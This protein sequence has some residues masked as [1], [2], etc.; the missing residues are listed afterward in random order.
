MQMPLGTIRAV[1]SA[2]ASGAALRINTS[3]QELEERVLLARRFI[4]DIL[5]TLAAETLDDAVTVRESDAQLVMHV[6]HRARA[7]GL[8]PLLQHGVP[9]NLASPGRMARKSAST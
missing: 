5:T 3:V 6:T 8:V 4:P 7:S 1:L 9:P 2:D